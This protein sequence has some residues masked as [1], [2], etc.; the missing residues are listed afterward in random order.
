ML[1]IIYYLLLSYC[2]PYTCIPNVILD[3]R[4]VQSKQQII[5]FFIIYIVTERERDRER[6]RG[7]ENFGDDL[8][9]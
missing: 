8:S 7:R 4:I 9:T 5:V 6:E 2:V 1:N 3:L